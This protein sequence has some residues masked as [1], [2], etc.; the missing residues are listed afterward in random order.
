MNF[1]T[2][3]KTNCWISK[4][5]KGAQ[6]YAYLARWDRPTG[7]WLLFMPSLWSIATCVTSVKELISIS[8]LFF[9]G[10]VLIRGAGCTINDMADKD[11]D[12]KVE[13]T[14]G[15]PL[16][17]GQIS[18]NQALIFLVIQLVLAFTVLIQFN[19]LTIILGIASLGLII[20]YPFM[21]RITYWPQAFLGLTMNWGLIMGWSAVNNEMGVPPLVLYFGSFFWTMGYDT[22][23]GHMD[24][25]DDLIAGVKSTSILLAG[26]TKWY[27]AAWYSI[28]I[29]CLSV[30]GTLAFMGGIYFLGIFF[31]LGLLLYQVL[32]LDIKNP[33]HCLRLFKMNGF[34]G[35]VVVLS[36]ILGK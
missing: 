25:K 34:V 30:F 17:S 23:Y 14:K 1:T 2:D 7:I 29:L 4:L 6:P 27:V 35:F 5:P 26:C 16:A 22:I 15:R 10:T 31:V 24:R 32:T 11:I 9:L 8:S 20:G 33:S 36:I 19:S 12:K 18:F 13:R 21:K 3:I 28:F